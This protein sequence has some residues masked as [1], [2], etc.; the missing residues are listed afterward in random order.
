MDDPFIPI[1]EMARRAGVTASALRFYE[2]QG[3]LSS[4]RSAGG[5]RQY[6]RSELRRVAFIRAAQAV[7]LSLQQIA[8]ALQSLPDGRAPTQADW[9]RL[10][11]R[12]RPLR[13]R[14]LISSIPMTRLRPTSR[15]TRSRWRWSSPPTARS[16]AGSSP[17]R[18]FRGRCNR[19]RGRSEIGLR[20]CD[21]AIDDPQEE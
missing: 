1:A 12:W 7:G 5:R 19:G 6:P 8:A 18:F 20:W 14:C 21:D 2:E 16:A 17:R 10:S 3:L 4:T 13:R 15:C 9:T 11:R